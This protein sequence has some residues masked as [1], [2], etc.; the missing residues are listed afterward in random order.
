M[1]TKHP[2]ET[3]NKLE[4]IVVNILPILGSECFLSNLI[5]TNRIII[6]GNENS[7]M[8]L[9]D[10]AIHFNDVIRIAYCAL[11]LNRHKL[12][13]TILT[14]EWP[15]KVTQSKNTMQLERFRFKYYYNSIT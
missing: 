6:L 3:N 13:P 8:N 12:S 15:L 10:V 7:A 1:S 5:D 4:N 2:S 11:T 9:N 14:F